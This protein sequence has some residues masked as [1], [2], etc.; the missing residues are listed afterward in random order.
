MRPSCSVLAGLLVAFTLHRGSALADGKS[1]DKVRAEALFDEG[2]RLMAARDYA[3]AC[4]KFVESQSLDPAPGTT[5]NLATCYERAE[6][7][8]SAWEAFRSAESAAQTA[9]QKDRAAYARKKAAKL[10]PELS[11]LTITVPQSAQVAGLEIRCVGEPLQP[12]EWGVAVPRD[13][14]G[15][16]IV[17]TAP[18]KKSWTTRVELKPK[19]DSLVVDVPPLEDAPAPPP[20]AQNPP[21]PPNGREHTAVVEI[22]TTPKEEQRGGMQRVLGFAIG[23]AGLVSAGIGGALAL[24]AKSQYEKAA[25]EGFP[26][27]DTDSASAVGTGN[28]ATILVLAGGAVTAAGVVVWLTAPRAT[29]TV[30]TNGRDLLLRG[31][32]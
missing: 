18:G 1:P 28:A 19:G 30:G 12:P 24:V 9:G 7:L 8:A 5:L 25:G 6:K 26:A 13:G 23:G 16:E 29:V 32:F 10:Q 3:S 2:R 15:Y 22:P 17:A 31:S 14:G 21:T 11:R 4:P 20:V 27:R